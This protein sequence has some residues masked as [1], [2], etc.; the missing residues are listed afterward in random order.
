MKKKRYRTSKQVF[1]P[2]API[3]S[4]TTEITELYTLNTAH[5]AKDNL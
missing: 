1:V 5:R 3:T 4:Y 2:T